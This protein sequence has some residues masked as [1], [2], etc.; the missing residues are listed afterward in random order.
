MSY[1]IGVDV[2]GTFT[3]AFASSDS[4][5]V[6]SAKSPSTPPD[7][8]RGVVGALTELARALGLTLDQLMADTSYVCHGTT[9][10]LNALV[11]GDTAKIGFLTTKGHRDSIY[12]MNIEGR[13]AGLGPEQIQN[14]VR[15]NKP[16]V[17]L[18]KRRA[19][20]ITERVDYA[21]DVVV[22]LNEDEVRAAVKELLGDGVEAIAVSYLWSF[23]NP[24]HERRTREIIHELAPNL[25]VGL[26]SDICP[27]IR[28][29]SRA[30]TT[31]MSTQVGP[32]LRKYLEP[33]TRDLTSAGLKGP[34]LVMQGSGGTVAAQDAPNHAIT[35]IGSVLTGG[36]VGGLHLGARLGHRNVI[37]TDV[38]GT[39]FLVGMIVD[40]N[41]VFTTTSFINQYTINAPMMRVQ[42]IGSGG[43]AI[44]WVDPGGNLRV[45]PRSAGAAPGP[46]CYGQGGEEPTV[47]DAD[48]ALGILNSK[49]FLGGK[50]PLK[51]E[52]AT[53]AL[54]EKI[55]KPLK[56]NDEEAA[57]A[58]FAVQNSQTA[59]LVRRSVLEAGYDPRDF[60]IYAFGGAGPVHAWAYAKDIGVRELV[61][62]LGPTAAAF[63]AYGL[64]A[65]DIII[66]A[67]LSDPA[68]FPLDPRALN[69]NFENLEQDVLGRLKEQGVK[70]R[71]IETR[72]ELDVRYTLQIAEVSTPVKNGKLNEA[73]VSVI[74]SDFEQKYETLY[75]KGTGY[76]EAGLQA[77]TYRVFGTGMLPLKPVL[78]EVPKANGRPLSSAL[79]ERRPVLM[80]PQVGWKETPIYDYRQLAAGHAFEGPAIVEAPTTTVVVAQGNQATLDELG[81]IVIRFS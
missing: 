50:W 18:P 16:P 76:R 80:D 28:E 58:V 59:D 36:V 61:V 68:N 44:A 31:I 15:T 32:T 66:S 77:I 19:K 54:R 55:G 51:P 6:S 47:T 25:F 75:G 22:R 70:F 53:R 81:N 30:A 71:A 78:P 45:G 41:P 3:D 63:S 62:P 60:V 72:R 39:T 27:K 9:S 43:G 79:K 46:A 23:R 74:A 33:L 73:D 65:S 13:Y 17:L 11:T 37:T 52:L 5:V 21:G 69:R 64:A 12:I 2:G 8:S 1:A 20:E 40:N 24:A 14:F 4:G 42:S 34:L 56:L 26:S 49:F 35:T 7:F 38:G 48:L 10:T 29:Y 57:V 67:E